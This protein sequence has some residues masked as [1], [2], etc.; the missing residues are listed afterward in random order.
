MPSHERE[1]GTELPY[2]G[3]SQDDHALD[4][5]AARDVSREVASLPSFNPARSLA[6][7]AVIDKHP[8]EKVWRGP[9]GLG[10]SSNDVIR[11]HPDIC[12]HQH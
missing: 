1:Q 5:A 12:I 7:F 6:I 3:D 8:E 2:P 9:T 11:W 10:R 4:M